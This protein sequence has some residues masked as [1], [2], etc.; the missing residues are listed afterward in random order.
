[1]TMVTTMHTIKIMCTKTMLMATKPHAVEHVVA[2][3]RR[4]KHHVV[5][6]VAGRMQ[7]EKPFALKKAV[8]KMAARAAKPKPHVAVQPKQANPHAVEHVAVQMQK[9]KPFAPKKVVQKKAAAAA[10]KDS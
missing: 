5:G 4:Q 8:P 7:K 1:M 3:A 10:L 6:P 9:E 2:P